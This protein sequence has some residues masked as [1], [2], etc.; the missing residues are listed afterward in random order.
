MG[1]N[2]RKRRID[3]TDRGEV[4]VEGPVK[5]SP[6]VV[7]MEVVMG[8]VGS[9]REGA[10]VCYR[11]LRMEGSVRLPPLLPMFDVVTPSDSTRWFVGRLDLGVSY[12]LCDKKEEGQQ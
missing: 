10:V 2:M 4:C 3:I 6:L 7:G 8:G 1:V 12:Y 9:G 11:L 5:N